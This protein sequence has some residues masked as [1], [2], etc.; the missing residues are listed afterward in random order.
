ML[1]ILRLKGAFMTDV[2]LSQGISGFL[3]ESLKEKIRPEFVHET[4]ST[5][6]IIK[7]RASQGECEGLFVV[8]G[9]QTGGR[10]RLGRS[11]FSPGD[12]GLY[13]SLLLKPDLK[14]EDAV[15]IT[16]AA[17]VSVCEALEATGVEN[18]QIKWVNDIFVKNKKVCGIL[19]EA[20]FNPEKGALDYVVLGVG[21]NVYQPKGGFPEDIKDIAGAVFSREQENLRNRIAAEFLNSF[22]VYYGNISEKTHCSEYAKR[23]FVIGN[24]INVIKNGEKT[25]AKAL[26]IDDNCALLVEYANGERAIL[27][28]GEISIRLSE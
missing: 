16:T 17:A 14:P 20:S 2:L 9:Q 3:C 12:T 5:N 8:A 6:T 7:K 23:N 24:N 11:F 25:P 18:P 22:M 26:R 21:I 27:N 4:E 15:L 28:S 19:T 10:G 1:L 13:M